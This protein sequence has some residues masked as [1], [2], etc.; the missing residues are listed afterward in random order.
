MS[1]VEQEG[2]DAS[3]H[4]EDVATSKEYRTRY[5]YDTDYGRVDS[6][7]TAALTSLAATTTY[8]YT[9]G[10]APGSWEASGVV[11]CLSSVTD[12]LGGLVEHE[13]D[14]RGQVV[15]TTQ[16]VDAVTDTDQTLQER[17]TLREYDS[18]GRPTSTLQ[19]ESGQ[20]TV[21][22]YD[23]AGR[24][25]ESRVTL[26]AQTVATTSYAYDHAGH[27][28]TETLPDPDGGGGEP[29][30]EVHHEW[31]WVDLE[32]MRT[33]ERGGEWLSTYDWEGRLVESET[34]LGAITTT[35]YR[36]GFEGQ[37]PINQV[38]VD[39]PSG[40]STV[41]DHDVAGR[42]IAQAL[43]PYD[44]TTYG[45]DVWGNVTLVTD[46][47]G[48]ETASV[49][50]NLSELVE[51]TQFA[52]AAG[53]VQA[54][55]TRTYDDSGRLAS[56][57]GPLTGTSDET[58]FDHDA[59]GRMTQVTQTGITL[60]GSSTPASVEVTYNEVG[61]QIKV[62]Q[63]L[64]TS[65][66]LDR[67]WTYDA[68]GRQATYRDAGGTT[69]NTYNRAGW[70][71]STDDPRPSLTV[72]QG[73]DR[74]GRPV[75]RHTSVCDAS[76][77]G[78]ETWAYDEAGNMIEAINPTE[79]FELAYDADGRLTDV[80][81][82]S[83][84]ETS[85][86]YDGQTGLLTDLTDAAGTTSYTYNAAGQVSTLDDPFASAGVSTY[87]YDSSTGRL[88]SRVDGQ[89][90]LTWTTG[91]DPDTGRLDATTIASTSPSTT[92]AAFELDFDKAGNVVAKDSDV[93][94]NPSDGSWAYDY[95]GA[96]RLIEATGPNATG[97]ATTWEYGYDG[98]GNRIQATETTGQ[99][100]IADLSTS[101]DAQGLPVSA[102]D[103]QTGESIDYDHDEIGSLL[104]ID[105]SVGAH[106]ASYAYDPYARMTCAEPGA[107]ICAG[108]G[109][110]TYALD[111]FDRALT[112]TD[113]AGTTS[114]AYRGTG[115]Q[116][117]TST[118]GGMT[119]AYAYGTAGAPLA[120]K[121]G[122]ADAS[123]ALVDTHADVVGLVSETATEVGTTAFDP[124]GELLA[125]SGTQSALGYQGDLTDPDTGLVDMGTRWYA[126]GL[127]R[128]GSRDTVFGEFGSPMSLNQ[129]AYANMNPITMWDPTGMGACTMPGEC[130]RHD[131][132]GNLIAV[133]GNPGAANHPQHS[134]GCVVSGHS[135]S[136]AP[137][138]DPA[139]PIGYNGK[140]A[141]FIEG[142]GCA[143][144]CVSESTSSFAW[145]DVSLDG[146]DCGFFSLGC[147]ARFLWSGP[148]DAFAAGY[149]ALN[150][151]TGGGCER[152]DN[153]WECTG[154]AGWLTG[155]SQA[156]TIGDTITSDRPLRR[157]EDVWLHEMAHVEQARVLGPLYVPGWAYGYAQ[158]IRLGRLDGSC[159]LLEIAA[160]RA[161][162]TSQYRS[163]Y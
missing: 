50:T 123:Y 69:T 62:S 157:G 106:D 73:Y 137:R 125:T 119:T 75:C 144:R 4:R 70:L 126:P 112:R 32:T 116:L 109:S 155:F 95:D 148:N 35:T 114:Y 100:V 57:D 141:R 107:T 159:N 12:E 149:R 124:W 76:T 103:A 37:D 47:A 132:N 105:S 94:S 15:R 66:A 3:G 74:L 68:A 85:Y 18:L 118:S 41:T 87:S 96:G 101:Y 54:V 49:Y 104:Q 83:T 138:P 134:C 17:T 110:V 115:E 43:D 61:E 33:D 153:H 88:E 80:V 30:P 60:P 156:T 147:A 89:S 11:S 55:T 26:D 143:R 162:G 145:N 99:S 139:P 46:P 22:V 90:N 10:V 44:P 84:T 56:I 23:L 102:S 65:T 108:A 136:P 67:Y 82:D 93:Y 127:G 9:D 25:A 64:T 160:D 120:Q 117:A 39:A 21:S 24:L 6:E 31:N 2:L 53:G 81:R 146:A 51:T 52:Q 27:L 121:V 58:A 158:S 154:G 45:H 5:D 59:L 135:Y 8:G 163:C 34:P 129:Y 72:H 20:E 16:T 111:A 13:C 91:Y 1:P 29:S 122:S 77:S 113:G 133:G 130:V 152:Y 14:E 97:N 128:F 98:G 71:L 7:T 38:V 92:L 40:A 28:L 142:S 63:P 79:S 140:L 19:E 48:V 151:L 86:V 42:T 78:A 161:A 131:S 36:L 150:S